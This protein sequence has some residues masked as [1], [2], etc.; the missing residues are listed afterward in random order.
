MK[1]RKQYRMYRRNGVFY[2]HN[3]FTGKQESL[4]TKDR[5]EAERLFNAKNEAVRQPITNLSI[6]RAY[7]MVSDAKAATRTWQE[8]MEEILKLKHGETETRWNTAVKDKALDGI[9]KLPVLETRAEHF[10]RANGGREGEHEHLPPENPQFRFGNEL[11]PSASHP[12]AHVA[13]V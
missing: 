1:L 12:Q 7:L 3:N 5:L 11:A 4:A 6:A 2:V 13:R 8:V 10:L 9:R